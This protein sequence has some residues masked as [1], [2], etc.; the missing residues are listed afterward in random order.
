[1]E[2]TFPILKTGYVGFPYDALRLA[3]FELDA[4]LVDIRFMPQS[5]NPAFMRHRL[6]ESFGERYVHIKEWG[7]QNY[8]GGPICLFDPVEGLKVFR[9]QVLGSG[10]K[11]ALLMCACNAPKGCHR[12]EVAQFLAKEGFFVHELER[13][14]Y[15]SRVKSQGRLF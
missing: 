1:M 4:V 5:A 3:V 7:N 6:M 2:R 11:A 9:D 15:I 13:E 8:R 14:D 12:E 10:H